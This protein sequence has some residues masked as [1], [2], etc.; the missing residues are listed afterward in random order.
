[1]ALVEPAPVPLSAVMGPGLGRWFADLHR[2][3]GVEMVLGEG[4]QRLEGVG[5]VRRVVTTSGR[6]LPADVVVVGVGARVR[7][8]DSPPG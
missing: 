3:H 2:T 6:K 1:M 7:C 5:R 4:V 8:A